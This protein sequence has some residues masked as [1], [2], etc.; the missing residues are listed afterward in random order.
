MPAACYRPISSNL[1]FVTRYFPLRGWTGKPQTISLQ[2][3]SAASVHPHHGV[4][5]NVAHA[6]HDNSRDV[7]DE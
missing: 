3:D 1:I 7:S 6:H 2:W 4:S 5:A